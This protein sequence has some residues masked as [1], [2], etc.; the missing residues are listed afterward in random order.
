MDPC[1]PAWLGRPCGQID[2]QERPRAFLLIGG[3]RRGPQRS[4]DTRRRPAGGR[5]QRRA[6]HTGVIMVCGQKVALGRIHRYQTLTVHV[7][8]TTLAIELDDGETRMVRRTTTLPVRN[9]KAD[10]PRPV[11]PKVV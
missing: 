6:S 9:I 8:E 3:L 5:V 7:S 10:R 1:Q 2:Q 4:E 11:T